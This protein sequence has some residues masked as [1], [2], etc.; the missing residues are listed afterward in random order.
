M[1]RTVPVKEYSS[2]IAIITL[3]RNR[4]ATTT[5]NTIFNRNKYKIPHFLVKQSIA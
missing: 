2:Q 5:K 4:A 3:L 1:H